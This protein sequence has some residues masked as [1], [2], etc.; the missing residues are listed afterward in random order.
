MRRIFWKRALSAVVST[1]V[2]AT[3]MPAV[4]AEEEVKPSG[5]LI[6]LDYE[7]EAAEYA[8]KNGGPVTVEVTDEEK[9]QSMC[10]GSTGKNTKVRYNFEGNPSEGI[11]NVHFDYK[12]VFEGDTAPLMYLSFFNGQ[13]ET[14]NNA[15]VPHMFES[16]FINNTFSFM[17]GSD[18]W[19]K[20]PE[21]KDVEN[22]KWYTV[23]I[24]MDL[25]KR[26]MTYLIDGELFGT[27]GLSEKM[28]EVAGMF[29]LYEGSE[30]ARNY[31]DNYTVKKMTEIEALEYAKQ[32]GTVPPELAREVAVS[33][34]TGQIGNIYYTK[35]AQPLSLK[36]R[37]KTE[38]TQKLTM[39]FALTY[40]GRKGAEEVKEISL[41]PM[42]ER[43]DIVELHGEKYGFYELQTEVYRADGSLMAALPQIRYSVVNTPPKGVHNEE[44]GTNIA[45]R[46]PQGKRMGD[47]L[48]NMKLGERIGL[49]HFRVEVPM[50]QYD[51]KHAPGET[52][53]IV[54]HQE[55]FK[56]LKENNLTTAITLGFGDPMSEGYI[57][58]IT[59][60]ALALMDDPLVNTVTNQYS[61]LN[62]PDHGN[63]GWTAERYAEIIKS[64][65]KSMKA[66]DPN[67]ILRGPATASMSAEN[68]WLK[69]FFEEGGGDYVDEF[70]VHRY[71]LKTNPEGGDFVNLFN[72]YKELMKKHGV[73]DKP[74]FV[75]EH[76]W[77]SVGM[78]GY[79][80]KYQQSYYNVRMQ[81]Y[82]DFYGWWDKAT[83][84][85][86]N[87]GGVVQSEREQ[88]FGMVKSYLNDIPY[89]AKPLY[90]TYGN[91]N[92][93]MIGA[94]YIEKVDVSEDVPVFR[95]KLADGRDCAV[96]WS[97]S[98][99]A[100][101][102]IK[103]G[104][105]VE[106][107][108]VYDCYGNAEP[109]YSIDGDFS[110]SLTEEPIYIIGEFD[111]VSAGTTKI[112]VDKNTTPIVAGDCTDV[113]I[114]KSF[115][116]DAELAFDLPDNLTVEENNGFEGENA[117][118]VFRAKERQ[119]ER[120]R[121][122]IYVMK[123][124]KPLYKTQ[125]ITEYGDAIEMEVYSKPY[126]ANQL[127]H[128]QTVI[129]LKS[130]AYS[131]VNS[132]VIKIHAPEELTAHIKEI[133]VPEIEPGGKKTIKI[134]LPQN[135]NSQA[136]R[137]V[138]DI[139]MDVGGTI[140]IDTE[141]TSD[142]CVYANKKPVIDGV[143][144]S[145][146]W[147]R[148][149]KMRMQNKGVSGDQYV[150]LMTAYPFTGDDDLSADLY[151]MYDDDNFYMALKVKDDVNAYDEENGIYWA[152]DGIQ[153]CMAAFRGSKEVMGFGLGMIGEEKVV[154][155]EVTPTQLY[156]GP[157]EADMVVTRDEAE[158]TTVYEICVPW[159]SVYPSAA[160]KYDPP[161]NKTIAFSILINDNDGKGREGYL[162]YGAGV[163]KGGKN[164]VS[165]RDI[166]MLGKV[167]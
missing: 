49:N 92:A 63:R 41:A 18:G 139:E 124:G 69:K 102:A 65:Y 12:T 122:F 52:G 133:K 129:E 7:G 117:K 75:G 101:Q 64:L 145:G 48:I 137:L 105:G 127:N 93:L 162:E 119:S 23:D 144:S 163:G 99:M 42:E 154:Q 44:L 19:V 89:E 113:V 8:W 28:P 56:W 107:V 76:G 98:G 81:F 82:N 88:N 104:N 10:V 36:L 85:T 1:V 148:R 79:T 112:S 80:D 43:T 103:L 16:L 30:G 120:E 151:T 78:D 146:E 90:L 138:A 73:G 111:S 141:V 91:Y 121:A 136:F 96:A 108:D 143:L 126:D 9:G 14:Y 153:L 140:P 35:D 11:L 132:G 62:E 38:E 53:L 66:K 166:F 77:T 45:I 158:K 68:V 39:K 123:D 54:E 164:S 6:S 116:G 3:A 167:R 115:E 159:D 142:V 87:D 17:S 110:F 13:L 134:N 20:A 86:M 72:G 147:T 47:P 51:P 4:I 150:T 100:Q 118:A 156:A 130:N 57:E 155:L 131:A 83:S 71:A 94:E 40:E 149:S 34:E 37:N 60:H 70:H 32:G 2:L 160:A 58:K 84:Y 24:W 27:T 5:E 55:I 97:I 22:G 21:I 114:S 95:Y 29:F 61:L 135:L 106:K 50:G 33:A 161:S 46:I 26:T 125:L 59:E 128:W 67:V 165:F 109:L 31:I 152:S 25:T 74:L 157:I 15:N